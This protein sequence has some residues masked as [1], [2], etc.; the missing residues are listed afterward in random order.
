M[1][2]PMWLREGSAVANGEWTFLAQY[3]GKESEHTVS[4]AW[5]VSFATADAPPLR[6]TWGIDCYQLGALGAEHLTRRYGGD[7]AMW[8]FWRLVGT[9][10]IWETA[11]AQAFGIAVEDF[12]E[13]FAEYRAAGFPLEELN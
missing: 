7:N 12:Y 2:V 1:R 6:E 11:F 5:V 10:M 13:Q 8:E 4:R 9:G 3:D